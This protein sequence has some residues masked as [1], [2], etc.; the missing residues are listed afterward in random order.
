MRK[1]VFN[2]IGIPFVKATRGYPPEEAIKKHPDLIPFLKTID[3]PRINKENK[4]ALF[5]YNHYICK[6]IY[7]LDIKFAKEAIIP[8]PVLRYN[9]LKLILNPELRDISA[10]TDGRILKIME[11]P[12]K[13]KYEPKI[14]IELGTGASA[15]IALLAAKFFNCTIIATE[16]DKEYIPKAEENIEKNQLDDKIFVVDSEGKFLHGVV[17][18]CQKFDFIIS[19][20]PY[21]EKI[22]SP[23][24]IWGVRKHELVS[25]GEFGEKFIISMIEEGLDYLRP[26]GVIAFLVPKTRQYLLVELEKYLDGLSNRRHITFDIIGL[27]TGNRTRFL[28]RI[29]N[30]PEINLNPLIKF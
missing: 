24:N 27:K 13:I 29:F 26:G 20:P 23:K 9:F 22:R 11:E 30:K 28:F 5:L 17:D 8:T 16:M 18:P 1:I 25:V 12:N 4:D 14:G 2:D 15:I 6:D 19:N 7:D 10:F 3:P 21:Y